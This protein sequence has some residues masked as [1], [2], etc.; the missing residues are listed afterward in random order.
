MPL[1]N[2]YVIVSEVT[3]HKLTRQEN[4]VVNST[5]PLDRI[6]QRREVLQLCGFSDATLWRLMRRAEDPF[7]SA[8]RLSARRCGWR[9]S[10]VR[11]W[12]ESRTATPLE[13]KTPRR[14]KALDASETAA[15]A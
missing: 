11:L 9:E 2:D 6:L 3:R 14:R 10:C 13:L 15:V 4:S 7:P 5:P 8:V 1:S 12:I